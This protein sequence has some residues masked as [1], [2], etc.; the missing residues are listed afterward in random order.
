MPGYA[1][2]SLV[3][4]LDANL[5]VLWATGS[6]F[7]ALSD[8]HAEAI[9]LSDGRIMVIDAVSITDGADSGV[10][11]RVAYYSAGGAHL[12]S[13][14]LRASNGRR[15]LLPD[16][17]R[18]D[19]ERI[20]GAGSMIDSTIGSDTACI[21]RL[22]PTQPY[23]S[24]FTGLWEYWD[25]D[26]SDSHF[27]AIEMVGN[28]AELLVAGTSVGASAGPP[29][30]TRVA[31]I[32]DL[33]SMVPRWDL[34]FDVDLE[35]AHGGMRA[36]RSTWCG[37]AVAPDHAYL[38]G[39][40]MRGQMAGMM[41]LDAM[42]KPTAYQLGDFGSGPPLRTGFR[43][44]ALTPAPAQLPV[45]VGSRLR[46]TLPGAERLGYA[47]EPACKWSTTCGN[48]RFP[49]Q[50]GVD[51]LY[52]SVPRLLG[53]VLMVTGMFGLNSWHASTPIITTAPTYQ[54]LDVTVCGLCKWDMT[55]GAV[56]G[57]GGYGVPN[58]VVNNDDFFFYLTGFSAG[59]GGGIKQAAHRHG[60][61]RSCAGVGQRPAPVS[62]RPVGEGMARPVIRK[63]MPS[64]R[65]RAI[66]SWGRETELGSA[67]AR[68]AAPT[69]ILGRR[70]EMGRV[71]TG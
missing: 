54:G 43:G 45:M 46:N 55:T 50:E 1:G 64:T 52:G 7:S 13:H 60:A 12:S 37:T 20:Y 3:M 68:R 14:T 28:N 27:H 51:P 67:L 31:R 15:I 4:R 10:Q 21:V 61:G 26:A 16:I 70:A 40:T 49:I 17:V 44:L 53:P 56:P 11:S 33:N 59:C 30:R 71:A 36:T 62:M 24:Q 34:R 48:G 9:E 41:V 39:T 6:R 5:N 8:G 25:L 19:D 38:V 65:G 23:A 69:D 57:Q 47:V 29:M 2:F 63:R 58:G 42:F 22:D 35:P 66:A 32:R 18:Q